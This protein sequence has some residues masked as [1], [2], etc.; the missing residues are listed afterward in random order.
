MILSIWFRASVGLFTGRRP[1]YRSGTRS[2]LPSP[3]FALCTYQ[4][5]VPASSL[6]RSDPGTLAMCI[7][8]GTQSVVAEAVSLR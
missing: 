2:R 6:M 8:V 4:A 1:T 3:G 5:S 7:M